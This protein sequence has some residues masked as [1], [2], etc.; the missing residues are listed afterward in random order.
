L[1]EAVRNSVAAVI[2][3]DVFNVENADVH[4]DEARR[5]IARLSRELAARYGDEDDGSGDFRPE[6]VLVARS[7]FVIAR[8]GGEAV[9]CGAYRPLAEGVAEIKRMY[10]EPA[11]RG[12]GLGRLVL[13]ELEARARRDGYA[14]VRL[15]TGT[16]QPEAMKLYE[17]AGYHRI[18]NYGHFKNDPRTVCF[19]KALTGV[20]A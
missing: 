6:D 9:A 16:E 13:A 10:V 2:D 3:M 7:G 5:L 19:E 14:L 12:R 8:V 15:D 20:S 17:T 4:S 18:P 1:V 11:F